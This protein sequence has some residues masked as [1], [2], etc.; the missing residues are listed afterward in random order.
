MVNINEN[1]LRE[2]GVNAAKPNEL[3]D[4]SSRVDKRIR[5]E[6]YVLIPG[7][8]TRKK[9]AEYDKMWDDNKDVDIEEAWLKENLR[10]YSQFCG[11]VQQAVGE[12][13]KAAKYKKAMI[14]SWSKP[15]QTATTDTSARLHKTN[16]DRSWLRDLGI[17]GAD[18]K[19]TMDELVALAYNE[20]ELRVGNVLAN[21]MTNQQLDEFEAINDSKGDDAALEWLEQN[22]PHYKQ[23]VTDEHK[24]LS[25]EVRSAE[26]KEAVITAWAKERNKS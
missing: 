11:R 14:K 13:I 15:T 7:E 16:I 10:N 5:K 25:D 9:V 21:E 18:T 1:W 17:D 24:K 12:E 26:D 6:I 22:M 20:L 23:V 19:S 8:L 3:Q 4:L 2:L